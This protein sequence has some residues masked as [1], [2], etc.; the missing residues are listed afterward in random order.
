MLRQAEAAH[1]YGT[2]TVVAEPSGDEP[3]NRGFT[4][5]EEDVRDAH[6][7]LEQHR[8]LAGSGATWREVNGRI[9]DRYEAARARDTLEWAALCAERNRAKAEAVARVQAAMSQASA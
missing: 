3:Q 8:Q 2:A 7:V 5:S 9:I 1:K 6:W 4:P